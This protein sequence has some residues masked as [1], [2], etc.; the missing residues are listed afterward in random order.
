M[1][2]ETS[3]RLLKA[4]ADPNR[5]RLLRALMHA[6][7]YV[8]QLAAGLDLAAPTISHHLKKL[9][10]A[11]LV[12]S[13]REQYYTVFR[14]EDG[15]LDQRLYDLVEA[16]G[17]ETVAQDQRMDAYRRKI[18][19]TFFRDGRLVQLPAQRKKRLVVLDAFIADFEDNRE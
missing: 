4:L 8:E 1:T 6:P 18:L 15:V 3:S 7:C 13:T 2:A 11:G 16:S 14:L 19:S 12:T 5:L 10:S 9:E 17:D